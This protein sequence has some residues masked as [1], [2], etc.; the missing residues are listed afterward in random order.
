MK[1]KMIV[2]GS[3]FLIPNARGWKS[4][5]EKIDLVFTEFDSW[6]CDFIEKPSQLKNSNYVG[7][8]FFLDDMFSSMTLLTLQN[9]YSEKKVLSLIE[10]YFLPLISFLK[11][12]E[13]PLI[14]GFSN[15]NIRRPHP[16]ADAR[17]SSIETIIETQTIHFLHG[18]KEKFKEFYFVNI[19]QVFSL[20]GLKFCYDHRNFYA[21]RSHL[22][23]EGIR[24]LASIFLQIIERIENPRK[25]VFVLD[26][27]NT[28]WGGVVG[29]LGIEGIQIGQDGIGKAF[30]DFQ[31]EIKKLAK[32]GTILVIASKNNHDDVLEVL[33]KHPAMILKKNDFSSLKINWEDKAYNIR[34]IASELGLSL[35]SFVFWDDSA[36][37]RDMVRTHLPELIVVEPPEDVAMWPSYL[38]S[39]PFFYQFK[40]VDSD[41][42]K[43]EQYKIRANFQSEFSDQIDRVSYLKKISMQP[44]DSLIDSGTI[45][46][47]FQLI[48][49][50][51][52]FNLRTQRHSQESLNAIIDRQGNIP[53]IFSLKDKFGDH[54]LVGMVLLQTTES[55]KVAWID[56]FIM[57][58]RVIGRYLEFWLFERCIS[59]LKTKGIEIVYAE[60]VPTKKNQIIQDFLLTLGFSKTEDDI[61]KM[62]IPFKQPIK[63]KLNIEEAKIP[64]LEV[65][66]I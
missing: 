18:L 61:E 38:D 55:E 58:C 29:D 1:K 65:F 49:K 43:S 12:G 40:Y 35:D 63:W 2:Y 30:Q 21:V 33:E 54:G 13:T 24:T 7:F 34:K 41:L 27:D 8:V 57:S 37:E 66:K 47:A 14:L 60:Y 48:Q 22:S 4:L 51:N 17:S 36:I 39:L 25:K 31:I 5:S 32:K 28:L 3:S 16:I 19:N 59:H 45:N 46:R 64:N 26:C 62:G 53:L 10:D 50:T 6:K 11:Q 42:K 44:I 20:E 56:T 52:Q 23:R 9:E 15:R